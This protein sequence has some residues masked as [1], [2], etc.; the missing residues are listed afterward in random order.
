MKRFKKILKWTGIILLTL[1]AVISVV[2]AA[3]QQLR[4]DAPYPEI[5]ASKDSAVIARGK[6]L[7]YSIAHCADCHSTQNIDSLLG[8]GIEPPLSGGYKFEL[9]IGNIY[10]RN[11]TSD[12]ATGIG[13]LTDAELARTLYYGVGSDGRAIFDFMPFHNISE[14]DMQAILSYLRTQKPVKNKVPEN[15]MNVLGNVIKA[16]LLKP[17]GPAGP[18]P[19]NITPD[20]SAA[21]GSYMVNSLGNCAGC[22]TKRDAMTGAYIGEHLA[23]GNEFDE[24]GY[25][26]ITPNITTGSSGRLF[27]WTYENFKARFRLGKADKHSP[28]PW[29]SYKQMTDDELRAIYNYLRSVKPAASTITK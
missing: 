13:R 17:T 3:R 14:S 20:T 18:I 28:M 9:P 29:N 4:F 16:F 26:Y 22:H 23:G 11:I 1:V 2:V 8:L 24:K 25:K 27:A 5:K 6:H 21:Y 12:S 7:V 15:E 10:S 19:K